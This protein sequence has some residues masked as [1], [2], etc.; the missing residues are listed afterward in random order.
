MVD[1]LFINSHAELPEL[2]EAGEARL[3]PLLA[4]LLMNVYAG[5]SAAGSGRQSATQFPC[6]AHIDG[7]AADLP[8]NGSSKSKRCQ[9]LRSIFA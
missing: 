9:C 2:I 1:L 4:Q 3:L 6:S 5:I 7:V 8:R